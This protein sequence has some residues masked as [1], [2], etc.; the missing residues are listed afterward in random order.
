[1]DKL[2]P[3]HLWVAYELYGTISTAVYERE[4][5]GAPKGTQPNP[6]SARTEQLFIKLQ[7]LKDILSPHIHIYTYDWKYMFNARCLM[8]TWSNINLNAV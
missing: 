7:N 4:K 3:N 6:K 5:Y 1:M 8:G 2:I